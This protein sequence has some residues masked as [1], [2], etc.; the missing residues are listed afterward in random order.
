MGTSSAKSVWNE[1]NGCS[2]RSQAVVGGA[3]GVSDYQTPPA[4]A[5]A[6]R[7]HARVATRGEAVE[8]TRVAYAA[9]HEI[10]LRAAHGG[11]A[12]RSA[13]PRRAM[14]SG[15]PDCGGRA[16]PGG[17]HRRRDVHLRDEVL[18]S[19]L[20]QLR[21]HRVVPASGD[22]VANA[23]REIARC[24]HGR[25]RSRVAGAPGAGPPP[26]HNGVADAALGGAAAARDDE[27]T[28]AKGRVLPIAAKGRRKEGEIE[29]GG[30]AP[31]KECCAVATGGI[32][33]S[34]SPPPLL[35]PLSNVPHSAGARGIRL[36]GRAGLRGRRV[37]WHR[38][39]DPSP[40]L[41]P[42]GGPDCSP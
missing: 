14:T 31:G 16:R 18:A 12:G 29:V 26:A 24:E 11:A 1:V 40:R 22:H 8:L 34:V 20:L 28:R 38:P 9:C 6:G 30:H 10:A 36:G 42:L 25:A 33:L 37:T 27:K 35:P 17:A 2:L 32:C 15:A 23:L 4:V 39:R 21:L 3:R 41:T 19:I 7:G 13:P 5:A